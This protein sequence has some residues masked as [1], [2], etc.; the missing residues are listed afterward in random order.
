MARQRTKRE[1]LKL[2]IT[3]GMALLAIAVVVAA[4]AR[5]AAGWQKRGSESRGDGVRQTIEQRRGTPLPASA[6]DFYQYDGGNFG[7]MIY[8]CAFNCASIQDCWASV[9]VLG[10][11]PR[12]E[13]RPWSPSR[14]KVVMDGPGF[15][16]L[17]VASPAWD[18][19][20]V[21][22]GVVYE[23]VYGQHS[24]ME[25]YAI[26]FDRCRVYCHYESG[27]FPPDKR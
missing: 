16:H 1:G 13:F 18:I 8:Y 27:G 4:A 11:P 3:V 24:R 17:R 6:T 25:F 2:A 21:R 20:N 26:D 10:A 5:S 22:R 15:Y 14:Y 12:S 23:R 7:G 19:G 9:Q